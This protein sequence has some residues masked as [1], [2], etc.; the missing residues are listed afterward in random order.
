ML[1]LPQK[2]L[3][4]DLQHGIKTLCHVRQNEGTPIA[5]ATQ[6]LTSVFISATNYYNIFLQ[7]EEPQFEDLFHLAHNDPCLGVTSHSPQND[8]SRALR[9]CE[10][11]VRVYLGS[12]LYNER[13]K[14]KDAEFDACVSSGS[15]LG[16]RYRCTVKISSGMMG[17][18]KKRLSYCVKEDHPGYVA[19]TTV[20]GAMYSLA[21]VPR[22]KPQIGPTIYG[23]QHGV[24]EMQ[25]APPQ[26]Q[27]PR[28]QTKQGER[29]RS[30]ST[31]PPPSGHGSQSNRGRTAQRASSRS[32][33][34]FGISSIFGSRRTKS[35]S[36]TRPLLRKNSGETRGN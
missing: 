16:S 18:T 21:D 36:P 7:P 11:L 14:C 33:S 19:R 6:I 22:A 29:R 27:R 4:E 35:N 10:R 25:R 34:F 1:K 5:F 24:H 26:N 31:S 12:P 23:A 28:T 3:P 2:P 30:S 17:S 15:E 13:S 32:T 9:L 8:I 20:R